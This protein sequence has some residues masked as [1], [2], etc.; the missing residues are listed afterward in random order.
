[1][2]RQDATPQANSQSADPRGRFSAPPFP[3]V[4]Q[5]PP[6]SSDQL[7][8]TADY[9]EESYDGSARLL[10]RTALI[11]GADSGIGRA[12]ALC[13]AKEGADILFAYLPAEEKDAQTTI[14]L[15]L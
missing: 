5:E 3:G 6:G 8:P 4:T 13:F 10:G 15:S 7:Q 12:V 2:S 11:T 14:R 1:M 9:G